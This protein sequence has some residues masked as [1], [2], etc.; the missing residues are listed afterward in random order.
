MEINLYKIVQCEFL[1]SRLVVIVLLN[2]HHCGN[3]G[4]VSFYQN[5]YIS[6]KRMFQHQYVLLLLSLFLLTMGEQVQWRIS[7][8]GRY[9]I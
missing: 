9:Y 5:L 3:E 2:H 6:Q 8:S 4:H 7:F 1:S